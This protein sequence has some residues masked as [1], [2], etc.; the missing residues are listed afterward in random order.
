M[1]LT[2]D[3]VESRQ[4]AVFPLVKERKTIEVGRLTV[5]DFHVF[6]R[7]CFG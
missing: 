5:E 4:K 7:V 1:G 6:V 3:L 2:V